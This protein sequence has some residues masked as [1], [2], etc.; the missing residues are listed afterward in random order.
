L[1]LDGDDGLERFGGFRKIPTA[2]L[3]QVAQFQ[4]IH[5]AS[6]APQTLLGRGT[7]GGQIVAC[8]RITAAL[9]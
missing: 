9:N 7:G 5:I 1:R 2:S 3:N 4:G 8:Q 6:V